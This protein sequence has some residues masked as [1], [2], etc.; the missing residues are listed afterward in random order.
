[1]LDVDEEVDKKVDKGVDEEAG[2]EVDASAWRRNRK[3]NNIL[4]PCGSGGSSKINNTLTRLDTFQIKGR[5]H[6]SNWMNF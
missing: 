1:M 2:R 6:E 5:P 3:N 4:D